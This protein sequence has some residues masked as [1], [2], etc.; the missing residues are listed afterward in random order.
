MKDKLQIA[1][2]IIVALISKYIIFTI[3]Y[4]IQHLINHF[5]ILSI[6]V[7]QLASTIISIHIGFLLLKNKTFKQ[8]SKIFFIV[9]LV[10][11]ILTFLGI[12]MPNPIYS[13]FHTIIVSITVM[14]GSLIVTKP[15][16]VISE[17]GMIIYSLP[18]VFHI[19]SVIIV[20]K[21]YETV[22]GIVSIFT[23]FITE[24]FVGIRNWLDHGFINP[25][26][27]KFFHYLVFS[28]ILILS[29]LYTYFWAKKN[30]IN[31]I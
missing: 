28:I 23:P 8:K 27:E 6:I 14:Y 7:V 29:T 16:F 19:D 4:N 17:V 12:F 1:L 20:F 26:S 25:Y 3:F 22:W 2:A 10:N 11:V 31:I 9:Y 30:K 15:Q 13:D 21:E 24:I 18:I 5:S